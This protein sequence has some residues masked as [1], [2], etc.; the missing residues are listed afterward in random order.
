MG[1]RYVTRN[2]EAEPGAAFVLIACIIKPE[3]R[4]EYLLAQRGGD[5]GAVIVHGDGQPAMVAMPCN[6]DGGGVP[7]R[8][9]DEIGKAALKCGRSH[10]DD[11][12][13]MEV[14]AGSVAVPL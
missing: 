9:G 3:K 10:S 5:A 11:R 13:T 14:D 4:L 1:A 12:M 6:C 7:S 8:I 2:R